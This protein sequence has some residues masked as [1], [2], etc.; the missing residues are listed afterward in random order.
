[1][2]RRKRC[3]SL[4]RDAGLVDGWWMR[5]ERRESGTFVCRIVIGAYSAAFEHV[6]RRGSRAGLGLNGKVS[7]R[8]THVRQRWRPRMLRHDRELLF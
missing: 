4:L 1:M 7:D 5:L 6:Q 3:W 8:E 2:S